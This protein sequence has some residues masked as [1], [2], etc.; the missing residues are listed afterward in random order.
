MKS[1]QTI[2][3]VLKVGKFILNQ[4]MARPLQNKT[5]KLMRSTVENTKQKQNKDCLKTVKRQLKNHKNSTVYKDI[6]PKYSCFLFLS[7]LSQFEP[8][9]PFLYP[10]SPVSGLEGAQFYTMVT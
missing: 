8:V 5:N 9:S 1:G 6:M 4:Q 7:F 3:Y 2:A 10:R